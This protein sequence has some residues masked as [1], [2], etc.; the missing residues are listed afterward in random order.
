[1]LFWSLVS[2]VAA[3]LAGFLGRKLL[4][5]S[6]VQASAAIAL[7]AGVT[8]PQLSSEGAYLAAVCT[9]AS[10]AA[11]SSEKMVYTPLQMA[12]VSGL[13]GLIAYVGRDCLVGV[14]GRLGTYA[15]AA[16]LIFAGGMRAGER[17][18]LLRGGSMQQ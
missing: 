9:C 10:Y 13:C 17:L 4:K 15:A 18:Q 8:L 11:M 7:L 1:M 12:G 2:A 5:L 16:V 3:G 14:G 6:S